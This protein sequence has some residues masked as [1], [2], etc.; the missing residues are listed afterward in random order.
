MVTRSW[1]SFRRQLEAQGYKWDAKT[2]DR[3]G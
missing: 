1:D 2:R 3:G